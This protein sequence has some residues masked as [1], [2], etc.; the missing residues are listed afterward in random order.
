MGFENA[1]GLETGLGKVGIPQGVTV[2]EGAPSDISVALVDGFLGAN[3]FYDAE[4]TAPKD[5]T[6]SGFKSKLVGLTGAALD[7][8]QALEDAYWGIAQNEN[9]I[10]GYSAFVD[11]YP[12]SSYSSDARDRIA[13]IEA[14]QPKYSPAEQAERDLNLSREEKRDIQRNLTILDH[15]PKGV[16]GL[17]GPASRAAITSWQRANFFEVTGFLDGEQIVK[18]RDQGQKRADALAREAARQAELERNRDIAFW[19][20]TG[21]SGDESDIRVYLTEF[22]DGIYGEE[23]KQRLAQIEAAKLDRISAKERSDWNRVTNEDS[24]EAYQAYLASYP[25]GAFVEAANTRISALNRRAEVKERNA[26]ARAK[27]NALGL[28]RSVWRLVEARLAQLGLEPGEVDGKPNPDTR[29]AIRNYQKSSDLPVTGFL[30]RETL[31]RL[32]LVIKF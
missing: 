28:D 7:P 15:D 18:L 27:E 23:A 10:E 4:Q 3:S 8:E 9:S 17:I 19:K 31:S 24:I 11:R 21:A 26:A 29:R 5:V 20:S 16:D 1:P 13:V 22:P 32:I 6:I 14:D 2:L 25:N 12:N 30:D